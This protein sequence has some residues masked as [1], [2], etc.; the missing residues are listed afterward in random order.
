MA[1]FDLLGKKTS[2]SASKSNEKKVVNVPPLD[3]NPGALRF[4]FTL[5]AGL[6]IWLGFC[7]SPLGSVAL[8]GQPR[9]ND[10]ILGKTHPLEAKAYLMRTPPNGILFCP[11]YWSDW[12]QTDSEISVFADYS[13]SVPALV[14]KDYQEIFAG[15]GGWE[16]LVEKYEIQSILADKQNQ[17]E[18]IRGIRRNPTNW[19]IVHED[20]QSVYVRKGER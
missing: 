5:I 14:L 12:L 20:Q 10:Q 8:G 1:S 9:S 17:P 19:K 13:Q 16:K 7:F 2:V 18:L 3:S 6:A 15:E 4:A 11:N